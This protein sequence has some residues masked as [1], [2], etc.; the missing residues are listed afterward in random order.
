MA[1]PTLIIDKAEFQSVVN[2]LEGKQTFPNP[3]YLWKAVE[4]TSWAKR[5]SPRPL[6]A[7]V[8]YCR[9]KELGIVTRTKGGKRGA[10]TLT[11]EHK[12]AMQ[13]GRTQ[14]TPRAS[15][16]QGYS[17]TFKELKR[18]TPTRWL[19]MV[20]RAEEGSLRAAISLKCL[21]CTS[22]QV[23]EIKDCACV[24]CS[25]YPHRPYKR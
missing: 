13:V 24:E 4:A 11:P 22:F 9:A 12:A 14:R 10:S 25:L 5:Q 20:E 6:T 8:A 17:T 1:K 18:Q 23:Q 16:M 15:K 3:S 7:S 2:D 19:P 21:D